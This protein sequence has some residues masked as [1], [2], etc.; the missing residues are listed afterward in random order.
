MS[1]GRTFPGCRLIPLHQPG[2]RPESTSSESVG[3]NFSLSTICRSLSTIIQE[4]YDK[5]SFGVYA[6]PHRHHSLI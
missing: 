2:N 3:Q 5:E 1:G 4:L 6:K